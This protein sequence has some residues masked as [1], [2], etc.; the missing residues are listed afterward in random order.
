[1]T[2]FDGLNGKYIIFG[3]KSAS[4][5]SGAPIAKTSNSKLYVTQLPSG[6]F[7]FMKIALETY[8]ND[9]IVRESNI[10]RELQLIAREIDNDC[11][12]K[13]LGKPNYGAFFPKV[14]ETFDAGPKKAMFLG[15]D[16][17]IESYQQF[18]PL[19]SLTGDQRID[20]QTGHWILGKLL[21]ILAFIHSYGYSLKL[22]NSSNILLETNLHGVFILDF[23]A[24]QKNIDSLVMSQ[25]IS[26]A[27]KIVWYA[28][29]GTNSES[30]PHDQDIMSLEHHHIYLSFLSK[31]IEGTNYTTGTV[32]DKL[33]ELSDG[34]W[35]K[36][37]KEDGTPGL[38]R[39]FHKFCTYPKIIIKE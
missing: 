15:F 38:K 17:N 20:L 25:E 21:K 5:S 14:L 37:Q 31:L 28:T 35:P 9:S 8:E 11:Q 12:N 33:Y 10:L 32:I 27:A 34:I 18:S 26:N 23:S 13:G 6:Q 19:S 1:M 7:G 39:Q 30:S 22:I 4:I 3:L 2:E 36:V 24:A 16:E 29:G